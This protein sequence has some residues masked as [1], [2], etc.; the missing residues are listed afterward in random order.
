MCFG[1]T[2]IPDSYK[3]DYKMPLNDFKK[4]QLGA[5][6]DPIGLEKLLIK[7]KQSATANK[8]SQNPGLGYPRI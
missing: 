5:K 6:L 2:R 1:Q 4:I 3:R 8:S 7:P